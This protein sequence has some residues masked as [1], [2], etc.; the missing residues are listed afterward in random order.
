MVR[1]CSISPSDPITPKVSFCGGSSDGD[2][3]ASVGEE[4]AEVP[5]L[6]ASDDDESQAARRPAPSKEA[7][8]RRTP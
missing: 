6:D 1:N 4:P 5:E 2:D 7:V 3:E 8:S